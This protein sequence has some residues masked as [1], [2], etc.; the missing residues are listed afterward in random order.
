MW[1]QGGT[2]D[3]WKCSEG[4]LSLGEL[5]GPTQ[6]PRAGNAGLI[7]KKRRGL[8]SR[9]FTSP[10]RSRPAR[11]SSP[12]GPLPPAF[13]PGVALCAKPWSVR[14][15]VRSALGGRLPVQVHSRRS[16]FHWVPVSSRRGYRRLTESRSNQPPFP[17]KVTPRTFGVPKLHYS[18][19]AESPVISGRFNAPQAHQTPMSLPIY[20]GTGTVALCKTDPVSW[21]Q[22]LMP[23]HP[24]EAHFHRGHIVWTSLQKHEQ[25]KS[26]VNRM[27]EQN[28][29]LTTGL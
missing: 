5:L 18:E 23:L 7:H 19:T 10:T 20:M 27:R 16:D 6:K 25:A 26:N 11:S 13:R 22:T 24:V 12:R 9:E 17:G 21:A 14:L 8:S 15:I 28:Q 2:D 3:S 1:D 4:C 29:R